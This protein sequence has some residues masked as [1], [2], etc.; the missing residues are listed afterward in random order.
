VHRYQVKSDDG[1]D[2]IIVVDGVPVIDRSKYDRLTSKI[3]KE[4]GKKGCTIKAEDLFLPWDEA[5]GKSKGCV[6]NM[7]L[8]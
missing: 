6:V 7:I 8:P 5:A 2:N 1:F 3:V 4:F